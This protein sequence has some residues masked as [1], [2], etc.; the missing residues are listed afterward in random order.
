RARELM[1]THSISGIPVID[2]GKVA[3][4]L[5]RRDLRFQESGT[6][7]VADVM[8]RNLVTAPPGTTLEQAK[9]VLHQRKVEKLLIVDG[10]GRLAGLIT[11]KDIKQLDE[12]PSACRDARGRLRVAA[13]VGVN[14]EERGAAIV[15]AGVDVLVVDTAHGHSANVI[16]SVQSLKE[17]FDI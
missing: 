16:K 14:D 3:G 4:I 13:A 9:R 8:T 17:R 7:R 11:M 2:K 12:Y 15:K 1:E 10:E 6:A 5:T